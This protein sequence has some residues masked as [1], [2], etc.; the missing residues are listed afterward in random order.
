MSLRVQ[1]EIVLT[2]SNSMFILLNSIVLSQL[3]KDINQITKSQMYYDLYLQPD[4]LELTAHDVTIINKRDITVTAW[5]PISD[6]SKY[7]TL[8]LV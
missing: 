6:V 7:T 4:V 3:W 5:L 1:R 2:V 8:L